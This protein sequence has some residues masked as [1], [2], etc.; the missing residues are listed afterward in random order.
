VDVHFWLDPKMHKKDHGSEEDGLTFSSAGLKF[1]KL[2]R[3]QS[4]SNMRNFGRFASEN[5]R[6]ATSSRPEEVAFRP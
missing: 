3:Q 2:P 4:G 1:L 6:A 5:V